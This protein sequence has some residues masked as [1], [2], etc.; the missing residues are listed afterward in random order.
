[1]HKWIATASAVLFL[2]ISFALIANFEERSVLLSRDGVH[3][4][5]AGP[6]YVGD[7]EWEKSY[8]FPT[9]PAKIKVS[10]RNVVS[11][12]I[13]KNG[14][15]MTADQIHK[16]RKARESVKT[17]RKNA[18]PLSKAKPAIS[19]GEFSSQI[20]KGLS[21]IFRLHDNPVAMRS[22]VK[23]LDHV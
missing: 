12:A 17:G 7:G 20:S 21:T 8:T 15:I 6:V 9:A 18:I 14:A 3:L 13:P 23:I 2:V 22:P 16:I 11:R 1:M 10:A 4:Q 19:L 5:Y